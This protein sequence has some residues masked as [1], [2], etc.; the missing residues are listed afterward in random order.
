MYRMRRASATHCFTTLPIG[1][2]SGEILGIEMGDEDRDTIRVG[3]KRRLLL[4]LYLVISCYPE[5]L[6]VH[7]VK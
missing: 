7:A 3:A 2:T 4:L 1:L 6:I 5:H